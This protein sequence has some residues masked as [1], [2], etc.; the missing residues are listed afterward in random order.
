LLK[1][2]KHV[3]WPACKCEDLSSSPQNHK[4]AKAKTKTKTTRCGSTHLQKQRSC[5]E[6][7]S[8]DENPPQLG[9]ELAR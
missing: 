4:K 5:R 8:R 1:W 6:I 7:G 9:A 2:V 3:L